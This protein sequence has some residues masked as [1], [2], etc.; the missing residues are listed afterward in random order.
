MLL[1]KEQSWRLWAYS[2]SAQS[3]KGDERMALQNEGP[4]CSGGSEAAFLWVL[5][6]FSEKQILCALKGDKLSLLNYYSLL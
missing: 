3:W 6:V 2:A 5:T 1:V 4:L